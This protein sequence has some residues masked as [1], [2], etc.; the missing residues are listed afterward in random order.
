MKRYVSFRNYIKRHCKN[1]VSIKRAII[2][3]Y[4]ECEE[5]D[6]K[7]YITI[8]KEIDEAASIHILIHE[9]AH[10]L[11]WRDEGHGLLFCLGYTKAYLLYLR[12]TETDC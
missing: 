12:W 1:I 4:G 2:K 6:G 8:S 7:Y 10:A 5:R 9:T 11:R 3:D